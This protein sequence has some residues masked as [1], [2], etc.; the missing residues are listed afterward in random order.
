MK[1][2]SFAC[3]LGNKLKP[4][5]SANEFKC[6]DSYQC[7]KLDYVCDRHQDCIDG[8]D[9]PGEVVCGMY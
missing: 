8:S 2:L 7:I 4:T 6:H 5:C 9:E 3:N 1:D